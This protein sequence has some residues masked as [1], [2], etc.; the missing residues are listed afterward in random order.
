MGTLF[1]SFGETF[2]ALK[3]TIQKFYRIT[4]TSTQFKGI[5]SDIVIPDPFDYGKN[6]EQDL[7]HSLPWDEIS[8]QKYNIWSAFD[9]K[10]DLLKKKKV[11]REF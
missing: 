4:G 10:Y 5:K 6:R 7:D 11:E 2:G 8:P 9:Y 3:V 1:K